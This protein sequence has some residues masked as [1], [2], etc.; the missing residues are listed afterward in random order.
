MSFS[1]KNELVFFEPLSKDD[2]LFYAPTL[3]ICL[4]VSSAL[5][6]RMMS[7]FTSEDE[8]AEFN[9]LLENCYLKRN[10]VYELGSVKSRFFH[11]ALGLTEN[12][13]LACVYCHADAGR[14]NVMPKEIIEASVKFAKEKVIENELKGINLSF[15]V[16]GEPTF[17]FERLKYCVEEFRKAAKEVNVS[18]TTSV[19]TNGY[20]DE[21][22]SSWIAENIDNILVSVDG[23]ADIQNMQ[24]PSRGGQDSFE[25][26]FNTLRIIYEK[27]QQLNVRS[28]ISNKNVGRVKEFIDLLSEN[29]PHDVN[30]VL[31]PL[32]PL[33]RGEHLGGVGVSEPDQT[34]F[35][36]KIWEAYCYAEDI[37]KSV[38]VSTSAMNADRLVSGFC[39]AM[40]IPSFTVTTNGIVTTC[41]R[42]YTGQNYGYGF[43]DS[44][45]KEFLIDNN[46]MEINKKRVEIPSKCNDC[47][48]RYHCAG[49]CPD[50]R[51]IGYERC[52]L[53]RF[54]IKNRLIRKLKRKE[55]IGEYEYKGTYEEFC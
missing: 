35:A 9:Q 30:L 50:L 3:G 10:E 53:I 54:F 47:I 13:T 51:T 8:F 41:E 28:T 44:E 33:G 7:Y 32:V 46:K 52:E 37:K 29:F 38:K 18:L 6:N 12:C 5:A 22:K 1:Y 27:K 4:N 19:T 16:G 24:R 17:D 31:E 14:P 45:K 43:F 21:D 20:Y 49:D 40:F 39:G 25:K 42:D 15:A 11:I 26:V 2:M 34:E 23:V 55:D 48:G 36:E